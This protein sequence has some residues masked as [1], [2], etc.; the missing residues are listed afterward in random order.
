MCAAHKKLYCENLFTFVSS[1][2]CI[3]GSR[4]GM[5]TTDRLQNYATQFQ[6]WI[7]SCKLQD[8]HRNGILHLFSDFEWEEDFLAQCSAMRGSDPTDTFVKSHKL[9]E[10]N[11][12]V[13]AYLC[14]SWHAGW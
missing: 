4:E 12:S 9:N 5:K 14:L 1:L 10:G 3:T 2:A 11:K 7:D 6:F 8:E 13:V